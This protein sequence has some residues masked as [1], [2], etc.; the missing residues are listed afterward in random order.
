MLLAP[1]CCGCGCGV[2]GG[3]LE[4]WDRA[5]PH[6]F[7]ACWWEEPVRVAPNRERLSLTDCWCAST[8]ENQGPNRAN[9][10]WM[11]LARSCSGTAVWESHMALWFMVVQ[12]ICR[13]AETAIGWHSWRMPLEKRE[14]AS[15]LAAFSG[16]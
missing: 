15:H 13:P 11:R 16:L 1:L 9:G 14:T 4:R 6:F 5:R 12:A 3:P 7:P 10:P 2:G 8:S